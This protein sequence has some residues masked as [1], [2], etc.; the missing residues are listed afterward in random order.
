MAPH[1]RTARCLCGALTAV[2]RDEP[3]EVYACSCVDCQRKS[4][5]AFTY[6]AIF[7][8]AAVALAGPYRTYR[9]QGDSGAFI[10]N[11]FCPVCGV[12]VF[13]RAEAMPG[14]IG[15][16]AGCFADARFAK[17]S[18]LFWASRHHHWLDLPEDIG[19]IDTQ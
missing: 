13:F 5:S 10:E 18:K 14:T 9:R 15:I 19:W 3:V 16:A 1:E 17:P 7:P 4:G 11:A 12:S 6:A 2:A 8:E